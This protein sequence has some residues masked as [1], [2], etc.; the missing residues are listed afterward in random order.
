MQPQ[1]RSS[2]RRSDSRAMLRPSKATCSQAV[3]RGKSS[4]AP[5]DACAEIDQP[6][7]RAAK[8]TGRETGPQSSPDSKPRRAPSASPPPFRTLP[9]KLSGSYCAL[10]L[11]QRVFRFCPKDNLRKLI[12]SVFGHTQTIEF[13][14]HPE[15]HHGRFHF[16]RR[17]ESAGRKREQF[18]PPG[19]KAGPW[20]KASHSR[21]VP[22]R[23]PDVRPPRVAP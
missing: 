13:R 17:R 22:A 10:R 8:L 19:R 1:R 21:S 3:G 23:P 5:I 12:N 11:F 15:P 7:L 16:G 20:R 14:C 2:P 9:A 4:S 18:S 6:D